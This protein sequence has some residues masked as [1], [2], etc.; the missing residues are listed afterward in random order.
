M[1][2]P[3]EPITDGQ[4]LIASSWYKMLAAL[5]RLVQGAVTTA[6]TGLAKDSSGDL[7]IAPNGVSNAM[8]RQSMPQSVIGNPLGVEGSPQDIASGGD[9]RVLQCRGGIVGFGYLQLAPFTVATLPTASNN[10]Y[11]KLFV[12]DATATTFGATP[13]GGG[14]NGVPVYSDG[15]AWRIG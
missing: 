13:T 3:R 4:G 9:G 2:S 10:P 11:V 1:P 7:S 8:L 5:E 12:T 6:G 14:T 15:V